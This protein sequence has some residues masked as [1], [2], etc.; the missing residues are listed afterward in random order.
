M[1]RRLIGIFSSTDIRAVL[2]SK[3]IEHLVVM[4][5]YR[6]LRYHCHHPLRRLEHRPA[7]IYHEEHRQPP[8]G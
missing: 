5:G 2:F 8:G 3:E 7:K 6:H 4:K 1:D